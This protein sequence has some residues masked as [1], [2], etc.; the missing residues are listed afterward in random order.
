MTE[1]PT[2]RK[3]LRLLSLLL[4]LGLAAAACGTGD[5]DAATDAVAPAQSDDADESG[6]GESGDD[7]EAME[8]DEAM[9]DE[10]MDDGGTVTV[11]IE[12][13]A[14]FPISDSGVFAVPAGADGPGPV[15]PG[16]AYEFTVH[17]SPGD[18]LSFATMFVQTNDWFFAP[19]PEGIELF[20]ADGTPLAG[21]VTDRVFT[22]DAGTEADQPVGEG[23]D[24]APRQSGPTPGRPTLTTPFG[25]SSATPRTMSASS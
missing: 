15:L 5:D 13:V 6:D 14:S 12:N 21:D 2:R 20:D 11:T 10:A 23:A 22:F 4:A 18:R 19:D 3:R 7:A 17:A 1:S 25:G 9:E 16:E 24:Q 8:D